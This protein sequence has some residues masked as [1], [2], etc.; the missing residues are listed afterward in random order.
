MPSL[1]TATGI[2]APQHASVACLPLATARSIPRPVNSL[3]VARKYTTTVQRARP[4]TIAS[5]ASSL[6]AMSISKPVN[7]AIA[8]SSA[9]KPTPSLPC[10]KLASERIQARRQRVI[11]NLT[12]PKK[13]PTAP[14]ST[15]QSSS[16]PSRAVSPAVKPLKSALKRKDSRPRVIPPPTTCA[17]VVSSRY[18]DLTSLKPRGDQ[19]YCEG[20][21]CELDPDTGNRPHTEYAPLYS[22]GIACTCHN[23]GGTEPNQL[24]IDCREVSY[25]PCSL[26]LFPGLIQSL[27]SSLREQC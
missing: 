26:S 7:Q 11:A 14:A 5:M 22:F 8:S 6:A 19:P 25:C 2:P 10:R 20:R 12:A 9:T 18:L 1:A 16:V 3:P 4:S 21:Y 13:R 27:E 17:P 23:A 15:H 24:F